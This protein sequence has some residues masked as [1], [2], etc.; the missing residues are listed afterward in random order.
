V[1]Q[2][3]TMGVNTTITI[4]LLDDGDVLGSPPATLTWQLNQDAANPV[5]TVTGAPDAHV[6]TVTSGSITGS[7][8]IHY[9]LSNAAGTSGA[10][11]LITVA[12]T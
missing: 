11:E 3:V 1:P 5:I 7:A 10:N 12:P 8:S 6:L 9:I 2:T 4:D